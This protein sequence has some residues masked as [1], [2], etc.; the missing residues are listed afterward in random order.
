MAVPE[1]EPASSE[2][3]HEIVVVRPVEDED[4]VGAREAS[5]AH[6]L[7]PEPDQLVYCRAR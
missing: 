4:A 6:R 5:P 3:R 7:E 1:T 2:R